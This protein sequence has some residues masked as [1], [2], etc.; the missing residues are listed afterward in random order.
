MGLD[1]TWFR[2][3]YRFCDILHKDTAFE[4]KL[5]F[6][7]AIHK[8]L[9]HHSILLLVRINFLAAKEDHLEEVNFVLSDEDRQPEK[10]LQSVRVRLRLNMIAEITCTLTSRS[11]F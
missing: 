10:N 2:K 5:R 1:R 8:R 3:G 9:V 11:L 4:L 6:S 7:L